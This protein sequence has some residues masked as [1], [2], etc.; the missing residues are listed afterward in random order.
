MTFVSYSG[1]SYAKFALF[2]AKTVQEM[3]PLEYFL[4]LSSSCKSV[5]LRVIDLNDYSTAEFVLNRPKIQQNL[6]DSKHS[7]GPKDKKA[8]D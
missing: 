3:M 2:R 7:S 8:F 6:I 4:S 5:R 1:N